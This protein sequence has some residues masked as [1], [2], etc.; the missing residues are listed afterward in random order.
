MARLNIDVPDHTIDRVVEYATAQG[1]TSHMGEAN[2]S[3]AGLE[4]LEKG[5]EASKEGNQVEALKA[6]VARLRQIAEAMGV[7]ESTGLNG[8]VG[9]MVSNQMNAYRLGELERSDKEAKEKLKKLEEERDK[10]KEELKGE[11]EELKR[12]N[13]IVD[14]L[15]RLTPIA[16]QAALNHIDR[17]PNGVVGQSLSGILGGHGEQA[18]LEGDKAQQIGSMFLE[19]FPGELFAKAYNAMAVLQQ[20]PYEI[21]NL[22]DKYEQYQDQ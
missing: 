13:K 5:L 11:Q 20:N 8:L 7:S 14:I 12:Q 18:K 2:K 19:A 15:E 3:K 10:L 1:I 9:S 21:D 6:E 22:L 4:L 16:T 17:N